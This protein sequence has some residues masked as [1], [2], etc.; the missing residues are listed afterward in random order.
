MKKTVLVSITGAPFFPVVCLVGDTFLMISS[1]MSFKVVL[2]MSWPHKCPVTAFNCTLE[3]L[4]HLR[5]GPR[6]FGLPIARTKVDIFS[7]NK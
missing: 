7:C 1:P 5:K 4:F 6:I 2:E 3:L